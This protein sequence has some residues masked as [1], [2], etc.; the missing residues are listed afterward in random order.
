[1]SSADLRVVCSC[2]PRVEAILLL[3]ACVHADFTAQPHV[4]IAGERHRMMNGNA[5][6]VWRGQGEESGSETRERVSS[7]M[8][9]TCDFETLT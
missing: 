8:M 6:W 1:M 7:S 3:C 9:Y 2:V 4:A 5:L